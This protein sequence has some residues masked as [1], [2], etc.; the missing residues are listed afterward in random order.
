[1]SSVSFESRIAEL[2]AMVGNGILR[3]T[4]T[5]DQVYAQN[6]HESLDFRHPHGGQAKY[7]EEPLFRN[8]DGYL[9]K[10][11]DGILDDGGRDAM[12]RAMDDLAGSGGVATHAP[13]EH[14]YLRGS[15]H[16]SVTSEDAEIYDRPPLVPRLSEAAL[17]ASSRGSAGGWLWAHL[18]GG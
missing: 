18:G 6:Q 12:I 8:M 7:L 4:V 15:G 3:G 10:I 1:M 9:R 5:V 16:P 17:S 13:I 11:A 14:G 2:S